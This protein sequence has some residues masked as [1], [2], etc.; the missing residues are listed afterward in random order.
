M[1]KKSPLRCEN[2]KQ[3]HRRKGDCAWGIIDCGGADSIHANVCPL[4]TDHTG[5]APLLDCDEDQLPAWYRQ[6]EL[7]KEEDLPPTESDRL[8]TSLPKKKP[9]KKNS[10]DK[11]SQLEFLSTDTI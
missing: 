8:I 1:V 11:R 5:Y 2:C 10:N 3:F 4:F 7:I 9:R 6:K